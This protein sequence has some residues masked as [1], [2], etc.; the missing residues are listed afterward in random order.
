L[1]LAQSTI[2]KDVEDLK[3]IF[4]ETDIEIPE[5]NS[6]VSLKADRTEVEALKEKAREDRRPR[7]LL[8]KKQRGH[9]GRS[10]GE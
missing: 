8:Q 1:E 5:C 6:K 10:R 3:N 4:L 9:L 2:I 7:K